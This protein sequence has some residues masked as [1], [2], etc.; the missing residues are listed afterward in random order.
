MRGQHVRRPPQPE[1]RADRQRQPEHQRMTA[2]HGGPGQRPTGGPLHQLVDVRVGHAVQ[3]VG[4]RRREQAAEQRVEDQQRIDGAAVGQQHRGDRGDEQQLDH[5]R[6]RQGEVAE[7]RRADSV[8][9]PMDKAAFANA[10]AKTP[11]GSPQRAASTTDD[12]RPRVNGR[13]NRPP[14]T[15]GGPGSRTRVG[16]SGLRRRAYRRSA[17]RDHTRRDLCP[18]PPESPRRLD[19]T[20]LGRGGHRSG[21]GGGRGAEG[22]QR[23]SR[24]GDEPGAAGVHAV[25]AADAPRPQRRRTG[26]AGTA[27]CCRAGTAA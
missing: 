11:R 26:W 10:H 8:R 14:R 22:R 25:S 13:P 18:H 23:P 15:C 19:R 3:R 24:Y 7:E 4:A 12:G 9:R 1:E 2:R 16:R 21:A 27:S 5:P 17:P 6:L 20:G